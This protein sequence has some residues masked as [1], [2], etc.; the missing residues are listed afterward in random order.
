MGTAVEFQEI[1]GARITN[2]YLVTSDDDS[3]GN[4]KA[5][6]T[7][8]PSEFDVLDYVY[9]VDKENRLRGVAS[10]KEILQ[11][12]EES[13]IA[14]IMH[15]D[16]VSLDFHADQERLIYAVL[17][18]DLK[19]IP[20]VDSQSRLK[21]VVPYHTILKVF[22]HEFREDI[23][24]SGGI[25][26]AKEVEEITT[27]VSRLVRARLPSLILGLIG[28]LFAASMVSGFEEILSPY[29]ALAAFIPVIVYLSDAVGTQSQTLVV[30]MIALE[31]AFP[32]RKYIARELKIGGILGAIFA[33]LLF[34]A[35]SVGWGGFHIGVIVGASMFLSIVFQGFVATS[36]STMLSRRRVDPAVA[37]GPL[38]TVIS[39]ITSLA[40]YFGIASM[41]LTY[42]KQ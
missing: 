38:T 10:L 1:A 12:P 30:R 24:R 20:I 21:G 22:E 14:A 26:H 31:P 25:R 28:G 13:R 7:S 42:L 9:V 33:I 27:P 8:K 16:P 40:L 2:R 37:S 15:R 3:V 4:A 17:R 19:A 18:N 36:L 6:I 11:A 5:A 35:G 23:L 39:D 41:L 32:V 29:F 34:A